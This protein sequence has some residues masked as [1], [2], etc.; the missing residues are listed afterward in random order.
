MNAEFDCPVCHK[1]LMHIRKEE[2]A[3]AEG[4]AWV[5]PICRH[6]WVAEFNGTIT[7]DR[8]NGETSQR[9]LKK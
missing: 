4:D 2:C 7:L 5:C 8:R 1:R 3:A 6:E 9:E